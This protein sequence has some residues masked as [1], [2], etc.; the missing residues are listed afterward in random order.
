MAHSTGEPD[1]TFIRQ[2]IRLAM[3]GRGL[4]EPNPTVGCVLVK[5]GQVIGEGYHQQFGGP[6]AE[7]NALADCLHRGHSPQGATAYVTLEPCCHTNKKTPPCAPRLVEAKIAR[8]VIGCLD[9]NPAVN[10]SGAAMLRAAGIDVTVGVCEAEAKQLI[11]PFLAR[12]ALGRPYVTVKWA[13]TADG[14]IGG[15]NASRIQISNARSFH[16]VHQLRARCDAILVGIRTVLADNPLLTVRGVPT[17]RPLIRTVLD[18]R[19]QIPISGQLVATATEHP[20]V[21]YCGQEPF[22]EREAEVAALQ[23]LGAEVVPIPGL[24]RHLDFSAILSDLHARNA[25]H[26]LVE[27]G[28]QLAKGL[29]WLGLDDRVWV[30]QSPR[31]LDEPTAPDAREIGYPPV[32]TTDVEGDVLTEYL[33]PRSKAFFA[34]VPSADF[35]LAR[36]AVESLVP[37]GRN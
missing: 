2:A 12:T 35:L 34:P 1:E 20:L 19:L 24:V 8:A 31:S 28:G 22:R 36:A 7:P 11:A 16:L 5:D 10:G 37:T 25:T 33:N 23:A 32:A 30:F 6:H 17:T 9:P 14:K 15:P 21:V 3:N 18:P 13:Q 4:V 29:A 26:L 27:A